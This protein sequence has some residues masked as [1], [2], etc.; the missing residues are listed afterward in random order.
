MFVN[1]DLHAYS[2][3][4]MDAVSDALTTGQRAAFSAAAT[5]LRAS[6]VFASVEVR[7][8]GLWARPANIEADASYRIEIAPD[9]E[10]AA[11]WCSPDRY[12]SQS[13]E[14]QL[15]WT[16]DDLD[17]MLDEELVD[18]GWTSGKLH[19]L[20]HFRDDDQ[21]FVFRAVLPMRGRDLGQEH[22]E[23]LARCLL[24]FDRVFR[25]FGDMKGDAEAE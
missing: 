15:T 22:G 25:E 23:P 7:P 5:S 20:K 12:V 1:V 4:G 10:I 13:I 19:P 16:R 8:P 11:S 21:L 17:D 2:E 24:A 6:G 14:A 3:L 9:G 18:L